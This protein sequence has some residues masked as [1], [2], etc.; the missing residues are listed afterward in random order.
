MI[1]S[2]R[3]PPWH[4]TGRGFSPRGRGEARRGPKAGPV[5]ACRQ[6]AVAVRGAT[7]AEELSRSRKRTGCCE[8]CSCSS[9]QSPCGLLSNG[10]Y[11]GVALP[12]AQRPAGRP[13][14]VGGVVASCGPRVEGPRYSRGRFFSPSSP[15]AIG[16]I[17]VAHG[18]VLSTIQRRDVTQTSWHNLLSKPVMT[19]A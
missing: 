3:V 16:G 1:L 7:P 4:F 11:E 8:T 12:L 19:R 15:G 2:P 10:L 6:G 14:P 18:S 13:A 17:F 9:K 5:Q